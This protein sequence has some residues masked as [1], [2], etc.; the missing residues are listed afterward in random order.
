MNKPLRIPVR[1]VFKIGGIGTVPVGRVE[2]GT[3]THG[4]VVSFAPMNI[5][6]QV[7]AIEIH[8]NAVSEA[9]PGDVIGFN[10]KNLSVK[11]L[12]RG[13]VASDAYN[14]PA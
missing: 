11:D 6:T 12:H 1:D 10:V 4:M 3:L 13:Y 2:T 7:K 9:K 5:T 14:D 8:Q